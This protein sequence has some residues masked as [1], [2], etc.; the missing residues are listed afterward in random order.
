MTTTDLLTDAPRPWIRFSSADGCALAIA[1]GMLGTAEQSG[2]NFFS[3]ALRQGTALEPMLVQWMADHGFALWYTGDEQLEVFAQDPF[4]GGHPDGLISIIDP[5]ALSWWAQTHIP[6][7]ALD[8]MLNGQLL[9]VEFK[10]MSADSFSTFSKHGL[11]VRNTLFRKYRA[12]IQG[13]LNTLHDS[14]ND[15]LWNS[16]SFRALLKTYNY[17]RPEYCLVVAYSTADKDFAF[18]LVQIDETQYKMNAERLHREVIVPMRLEGRLPDP[19]Y[20]G[21]AADCWYCSFSDLCPAVIS[22]KAAAAS[23]ESILDSVPLTLGLTE[24]EINELAARYKELTI[25]EKGIADAKKAIRAQL[26]AT[27]IP[28]RPV[29]T[30]RFRIKFST[31]HR[32]GGI[33]M[34][35]L[36]DMLA[37]HGLSIPYK[38]ETSHIRPYIT[39]L[40]GPDYDKE[41]E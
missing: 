3:L 38:R 41:A 12:Q 15:E 29:S 33:D 27:I 39:P 30:G 28:D 31:V 19:T 1:H 32:K 22:R 21:T 40:F 9:L 20:D 16:E 23:S 10:T 37:S 8:L 26:E 36:N 2:R 34:E 4:R 35:A 18:S 25:E 6:K 13:Y 17:D 5:S 24:E 7:A 11:D 14:Q